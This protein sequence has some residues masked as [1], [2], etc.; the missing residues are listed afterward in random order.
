MAAKTRDHSMIELPHP[1]ASALLRRK[2]QRMALV[3]R[4]LIL[5]GAVGLLA[6]TLWAW[7]VPAHAFDHVKEVSSVHIENLT[8][9]ARILGAL[10]SLVPV[11]VSLAGLQRLWVLFGEY[12]GGRVFSRR[13]LLCLRDFARCILAMAFVSPIYGA[14]LSVIATWANAPGQRQLN[15]NVSSDDYVMLLFGAVLFAISGV[16]AEAARAAEDNAGFV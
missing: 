12:A 5:L 15:L 6:A 14:V 8:F 3:V 13:A 9:E 11:G 10:W 7:A 4:A 2:L 16:M 1:D